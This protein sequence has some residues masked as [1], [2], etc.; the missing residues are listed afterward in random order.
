MIKTPIRLIF[1]VYREF[2]RDDFY[3]WLEDNEQFLKEFEKQLIIV[4]VD[5]ARGG[6][7]D[8]YWDNYSGEE[9]SIFLTKIIKE[10]K[11]QIK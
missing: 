2:G 9:A 10:V 11:K 5:E 1:D 6:D 3:T 7:G 4:T 8:E